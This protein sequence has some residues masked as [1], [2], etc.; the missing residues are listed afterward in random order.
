MEE[1]R[2]ADAGRRRH[3]AVLL[4][5][6]AVRVFPNLGVNDGRME[7]V[8]NA[9]GQRDAL[10]DGPRQESVK[11]HLDG[12]GFHFL[13]FEGVDE[14]EGEVADEEKGD[15]LPA[16]LGTVLLC[17]AH[18][19]PRHVRDEH[20]LGRHFDDGQEAVDEDEERRLVLGVGVGQ[21]A[22]DHGKDRV[23]V[24]ADGGHAKKD[25][26]Q[27]LL[28]LRVEFEMAG[29]V[30]AD[31]HG[32]ER[33]EEQSAVS[34]V[35]EEESEPAELGLRCKDE[36][37]D[38]AQEGH[39]EEEEAEKE[40]LGGAHA[41]HS[42]LMVRFTAVQLIPAARLDFFFVPGRRRISIIK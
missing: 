7:S 29:T 24:D 33:D 17:G 13:H 42:E 35:G 6:E 21:S 27:L 25:A 28:V 19:T 10:H 34:G 14:P 22:G 38:E 1:G 5:I 31:D 16:G 37:E 32:Q 39:G 20:H 11:I 26:A 41:I 12:I 3:D 23:G 18:A 15:R 2:V 30:G 36:K 9:E 4:L 40:A 8:E